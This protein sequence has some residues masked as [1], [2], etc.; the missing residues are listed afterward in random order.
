MPKNKK[1]PKREEKAITKLNKRRFSISLTS[2]GNPDFQQYCP[3]SNPESVYADTL[4]GLV[5]EVSAYIKKWSLGGGNWPN[6]TF[7]D[8]G[9]ASGYI[10]YNGRVWDKD[11]NEIRVGGGKLASEHEAENWKDFKKLPEPELYKCANCS[12]KLKRY[13]LLPAKDLSKRFTP[14]DIYT[15]KEC[16]LC[17]ALC[18]PSETPEDRI[19]ARFINLLEG[20]GHTDSNDWE[21]QTVRDLLDVAWDLLSQGAQERFFWHSDVMTAEKRAIELLKHSNES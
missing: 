5:V 3:I 13:L 19:K 20:I 1:S 10:T 7:Y 9:K 17:G 2:V 4:E 15:D 18:F 21:I 16:P 6:P 14:G 12:L 11:K 8:K